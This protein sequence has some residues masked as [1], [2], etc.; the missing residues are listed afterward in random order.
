MTYARQRYM[1]RVIWKAIIFI[2]L[3]I[4]L[5]RNS[6]EADIIKEDA[7]HNNRDSNSSINKII[8]YQQNFMG[9][10]EILTQVTINYCNYWEEI[11]KNRPCK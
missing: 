3:S 7:L 1:H 11:S 2:A 6:I 4:L 9:F 10:Q 5:T 8:I